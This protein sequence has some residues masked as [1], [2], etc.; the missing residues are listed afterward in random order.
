MKVW[1]VDVL[2]LVMVLARWWLCLLRLLTPTGLLACAVIP[3]RG[4][5][6]AGWAC[7]PGK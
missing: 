4:G 5:H 1:G 3:G 2:V 7:S 6:W